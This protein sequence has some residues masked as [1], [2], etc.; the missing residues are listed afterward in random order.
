MKS[1]SPS[2][3]RLPSFWSLRSPALGYG[4]NWTID[5]R[6]C[7]DYC[8]KKVSR[9]CFSPRGGKTNRSGLNSPLLQG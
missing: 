2:T 3:D 5:W 4:L 9:T 6:P 7:Y 8:C 1:V